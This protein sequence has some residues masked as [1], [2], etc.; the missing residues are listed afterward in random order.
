MHD[1]KNNNFLENDTH[2]SIQKVLHDYRM[3]FE[4]APAA[5]LFF[6]TAAVVRYCNKE[7]LKLFNLNK[8][9]ILGLNLLE[10]IKH[11]PLKLAIVKS[12]KE[13][14]ATFE[15]IYN[16]PE[17]KKN[18]NYFIKFQAV[19]DE[20]QNMTGV[21]AIIF[22]TRIDDKKFY[23]SKLVQIQAERYF[24]AAGVMIL[25]LD[26]NANIVRINNKGCQ[27]LGYTESEL[28][29]KNW[30]DLCIPPY[31]REEIHTIFAKVIAKDI[32]LTEQHENEVLTKSGKLLTISW[33]NSVIC[34]FEGNIIEVLS[35]GEDISELKSFQQALLQQKLYD[36]LT[37][38][39]NRMMLFDRLEHALI[40]AHE[41]EEQV[42]LFYI[43]IDNFNMI[44]DTFGHERGDLILKECV[45]RIQK[46][47]NPA[48]TLAR[49]GGDEF[50]IIKEDSEDISSLGFTAQELMELFAQPFIIEGTSHYLTISIGIA[51]HPQ[52]ETNPQRLV[53]AA[54]TAMNRAKKEGK[55]QYAFYTKALS[56]S[57]F[58]EMMIESN[59]RKAL[60]NH[61]FVLHFQPQFSLENK[62]VIGLEALVRWQ[63]P[64]LGM[65]PPL[66]FIPVAERSKL[67]IPLGEWIMTESC[68]TVQKW[69]QEGLFNGK[70]AVNISGVQM[71]HNNLIHSI[72]RALHISGLKPSMLELE[73]TESVLMEN[74]KHW[75]EV[76]DEIKK[77][78]ISVAID[79]FGTGYS[80]LAYLRHFALDK[81][82][83]DKSFVDDL[84]NDED[85]CTI[86]KM[87]VALA[88]SLGIETL[89]EGIE[90]EEQE[91]YL[92]NIG[93][94]YAQGYLY[95][96]PLDAA[97]LEL[98]LKA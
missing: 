44:N 3:I 46:I 51:L 25:A 30:I 50:V 33:H 67:I 95:A 56:D 60:Q 72:N 1:S 94:R 70:I 93:C 40:I 89:A 4:H 64:E 35:T 73:I 62:E 47:L 19:Y 74:P 63:H 23:D 45:E 8:N 75:I 90:D 10:Y 65:V 53:Q 91:H 14:E 21:V 28:L 55:S 83:I 80:S 26:K 59:L 31:L 22:S 32:P 27:L 15:E 71:E 34:D 29:G 9:K 58:E 96:K 13:G 66:K 52:H 24:Q 86:A 2:S 76:L 68:K 82:K 7:A 78:G 41:N 98:F 84:P 39:P 57:L 6:D 88:N 16:T 12:L 36:P 17:K 87:I 97:S 11:T 43:D 79:D 49:F 92:Q 48:D 54:E 85:A 37:E 18:L 61:E 38:L 69:H 20:S 81:L 42:S 77:L 5:I